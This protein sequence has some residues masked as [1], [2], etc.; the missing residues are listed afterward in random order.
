MVSM[1]YLILIEI[2]GGEDFY[3]TNTTKP[4]ECLAKLKEKYGN[5]RPIGCTSLEYSASKK[6]LWFLNNKVSNSDLRYWA[7]HSSK[8]IAVWLTASGGSDKRLASDN[9]WIFN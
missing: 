5:V 8:L 1:T 2:N 4:R 3:F 9:I 7:K 6:A